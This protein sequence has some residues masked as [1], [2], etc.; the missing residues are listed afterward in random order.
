MHGR[1]GWGGDGWVDPKEAAAA[2]AMA[3]RA[4]QERALADRQT[5]ILAGAISRGFGQLAEAILTAHGASVDDLHKF[6]IAQNHFP[7]QARDY[8]QVATMSAQDWERD[9][10]SPTT[11]A[12][13]PDVDDLIDL[14]EVGNDA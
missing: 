6:R 11:A 5:M 1:A 10:S 7:Q 8:E 2:E 9:A 3:D 14:P 4:E 12:D 13:D